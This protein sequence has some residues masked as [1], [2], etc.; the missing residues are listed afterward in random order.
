MSFSEILF[1]PFRDLKKLSTLVLIRLLPYFIISALV[2]LLVSSGLF[3]SR[4]RGI[5]GPESIIYLVSILGL[6]LTAIC[7]S[8][9]LGYLISIINSQSTKTLP[10]FEN[11]HAIAKKGFKVLLIIVVYFLPAFLFFYAKLFFLG[12][13]PIPIIGYLSNPTIPNDLLSSISGPGLEY[14]Q[15]LF[16]ITNLSVYHLPLVHI[17]AIWILF[18]L[19]IL[20]MAIANF[21]L[22]EDLKSAF[23]IKNLVKKAITWD[24]FKSWVLLISYIAILLCLVLIIDFLFHI[25]VYPLF[26][27]GGE[28]FIITLNFLVILQSE[29]FLAAFGIIAATS[30]RSVTVK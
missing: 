9:F 8:F 21:A 13:K 25:F 30:I 27:S 29:I 10:D 4:M 15:N 16:G 19:F 5:W 2:L 23:D 12:G 11:F 17:S 6:I 3:E 1:R 22:K 26:S 28:F 14:L 20:P 18:S 7:T 24:Y